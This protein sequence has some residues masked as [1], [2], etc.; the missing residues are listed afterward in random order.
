MALDRKRNWYIFAV[1]CLYIATYLSFAAF[2][3][4]KYV[5][6][7]AV[8]VLTLY[9]VCF[10]LPYREAYCYNTVFCYT[11]GLWFSCFKEKFE[12]VCLQNQKSYYLSLLIL[13]AGFRILHQ[14]W[15]NLVC[16]QLTAIAFALIIVLITVKLQITN[17]ILK[18]CGKHLFSLFIL[19]RLPMQALQ[20][21]WLAGNI[22][23]YFCI[24][25]AATFILSICFDKATAVVW[26]KIEAKNA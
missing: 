9:F 16:Y 8:T 17:R 26:Q 11:A 12:A 25:L 21:T 20:D 15:Y 10:Q 7:S 24:C 22:L 13:L 18:Y 14:Y 3:S 2:G 23:L 5:A 6:I 19:Q 1:L 4:N